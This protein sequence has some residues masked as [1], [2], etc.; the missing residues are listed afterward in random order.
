MVISKEKRLEVLNH[1]LSFVIKTIGVKIFESMAMFDGLMDRLLIM[2]LT[3][4]EL[5]YETLSFVNENIR[6]APLP[7]CAD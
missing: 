2:H 7:V 4:T 1:A 3:P 5:K 6:T